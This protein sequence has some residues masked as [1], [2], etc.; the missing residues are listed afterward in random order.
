M[1]IVTNVILRLP[2]S[3]AERYDLI[4]QMNIFF[5]NQDIKGLVSIETPHLPDHWYGGNKYFESAIYLG[6]FNNL[7]LME[8]INHLKTIEWEDK[9]DVQMLVKE[10]ESD[11]FKLIDIFSDEGNY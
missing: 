2:L 8:F 7:K 3:N 1:S 10:Q 4:H 5:E 6:A 9:E 11:K